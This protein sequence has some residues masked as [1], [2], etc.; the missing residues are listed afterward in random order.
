[1]EVGKD[2]MKKIFIKNRKDQKIA[3]VIEQIMNQNGLAFVMHGLSGNKEEPHI[4]TITK[5]FIDNKYSVVRFDTTNTFGESD[6]D[7]EQ[8][9]T[10]NYFQDLEDVINW[11]KKQD[12]YQEPFVLVGQSLGGLCVTLYTEKFPNLIKAL[13]P[14][15][16]VISGELNRE[17]RKEELEDWEKTGWRSIEHTSKPGTFKRTSWNFILDLDK[18]DIL[19]KI[20]ELKMP[21]LL[22]V[23]DE[24]ERL[25]EQKML[26]NKLKTEKE[27]HI[28]KGA[29]HI[30]RDPKQLEKYEK[31]FNNWINKL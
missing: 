20:D 27:I 18:Y 4:K 17:L 13:A 19:K 2:Y 12:F 26:Y 30:I 21:I 23:G 16:T 22:I 10:T 31:I 6:G 1:M 15:A 5:A 29:P 11:A 9:T 28:I 8:A 7:Y 3:V 25:L 24:D 14:I